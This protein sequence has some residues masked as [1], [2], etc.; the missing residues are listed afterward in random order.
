MEPA[1]VMEKDGEVIQIMEFL[2]IKIIL[3]GCGKIET[4]VHYKLSNA[5]K[6]LNF[7]SFHPQHCKENIPFNLAKRI[8]VF[9]SDSEKMEYRLKQLEE[10]LLDCDYPSNVIAKGIHN[11]R[12]QGPAPKPKN[13]KNTIQLVTTYTSNMDT[14]PL[15]NTIQTL[16]SS[17]KSPY[18]LKVFED[19]NIALGYK[20]PPSIGKIITRAKFQKTVDLENNRENLEP[21]IFAECRDSRCNLR[22]MYIQDCSSFKCAN[23]KIWNIKSHINCNSKNVEYYLVCN[24]CNEVSHTGKTETTLRARTNNH[25][26][27]CRNG[28]STNI[29]DNH[30]YPCGIRNNCLKPPYFKLFAFMKLSDKRKLITYERYLHRKGYD[31]MNR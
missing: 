29:F 10:W 19:V 8:I 15:M 3:R 21:G 13:P 6:Y 16:V 20:Q 4:D 9:V 14:K 2:D 22:K 18:I 30:V 7:N 24:M 31:T 17:Q 28:S 5:H 23:G 27:S 12:L 25:I 1:K 26:S 11:A